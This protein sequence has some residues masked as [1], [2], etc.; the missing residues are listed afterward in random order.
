M[1]FRLR[2]RGK[3]V[4][5]TTSPHFLVVQPSCRPLFYT[6]PRAEKT[7]PACKTPLM[8]VTLHLY[9]PP[10][11]TEVSLLINRLRLNRVATPCR[12]L[13]KVI[14]SWLPSITSPHFFS[15][16]GGAADALKNNNRAQLRS[17][18]RVR[19]ITLPALMSRSSWFACPSCCEVAM[20]SPSL[21]IHID[22][23]LNCMGS[24]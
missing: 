17:K 11:P 19:K 21:Q 1:S 18:P 6:T 3:D 22:S 10:H 13:T 14:T 7:P 15:A 24:Y 12:L 20:F 16:D 23:S 8:H 9:T 4:G 2:Q 5:K